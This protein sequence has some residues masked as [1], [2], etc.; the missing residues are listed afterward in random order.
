MAFVEDKSYFLDPDGPGVAEAS[1]TPAGGVAKTVYGQ[2]WRT[3]SIELAMEG[4]E[5][6]FL[7]DFADV[8]NVRQGDALVIN[9]ENFVVRGK[10][11]PDESGWIDLILE[12]ANG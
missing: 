10:K 4:S 11:G 5:P 2:F 8:P 9:G 3:P 1:Y 7:C 12:L 6:L